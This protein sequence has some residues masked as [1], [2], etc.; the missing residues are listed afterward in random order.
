ML[1]GTAAV[2][3][4]SQIHSSTV[5]SAIHTLG[6][7]FV[8][9]GSLLM[10]PVVKRDSASNYAFAQKA[11]YITIMSHYVSVDAKVGSIAMIYY[12]APTYLAIQKTRQV[13]SKHAV[14]N[15]GTPRSVALYDFERLMLGC[16][17]AL[18]L[19]TALLCQEFFGH[20]LCGDEASRLEGIANAVL[21][22]MF[23][24]ISHWI[25]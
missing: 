17:G 8:A 9:Y 13:C 20:Y 11:V 21:Y 2:E 6:M 25:Q 23:F 4:Y 22:A 7:P 16:K 1:V 10:V 19:V 12:A 3:Y 18:I 15:D 24:S 14:S 5:N